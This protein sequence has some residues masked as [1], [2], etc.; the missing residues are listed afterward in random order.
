MLIRAAPHHIPPDQHTFSLRT[1]GWSGLAKDLA[2]A[3]LAAKAGE[4][5]ECDARLPRRRTDGLAAAGTWE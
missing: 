2:A 5:L 4:S 1:T 3:G